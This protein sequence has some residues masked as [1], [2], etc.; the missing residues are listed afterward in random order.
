MASIMDDLRSF[1]RSWIHHTAMQMATLTVTAATFAVVGFIFLAGMNLNRLIVSWGE[2]VE[3]SLYLKED[4][5]LEKTDAL[6][7]MLEHRS[8]LT[9]VRFIAR[10]MATENFKTQMASY[11]PGLLSDPDFANPFP[12][13]FRVALK[14]GVKTDVD[15]KHLE[16]VAE[17]LR[18]KDGIDDVSFGQSWVRNYSE[19]ISAI[20]ASGGTLVI[21]LVL[22]S[23]FVIGNSIRM[24]VA[25]RR[26]EIE[27]LELVGATSSMIRR[28]FVMEGAVTGCAAAIIGL[29]LN[30]GI[31]AWQL[32]KLNGSLVFA[33]LASQFSFLGIFQIAVF[34]M[35]GMFLGA[36][37]AWLAVRSLNDGWAASQGVRA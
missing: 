3:I 2:G 25:G 9:N 37:G 14:G 36:F 31:F 30:F 33:R 5:S 17:E 13:S 26:D 28:P 23:L 27:I 29:S 18:R 8:D 10:E 6:K 32:S 7:S 34:V 24:S 11:S 16:A 1:R 15:V 21:V 19:F 12:A 20:S 4:L 35:G 22:G